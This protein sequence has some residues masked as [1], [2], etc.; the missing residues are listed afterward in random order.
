MKRYHA[1]D[2]MRGIAALSVMLMHASNDSSRPI[3]ESASIAVDFFFILSGFVIAHAYGT[4]TDMRFADFLRRRLIRLYPMFIV[5]LVIGAPVLILAT[6]LGFTNYGAGDIATGILCNLFYLPFLNAG[7]V[8]TK[9]GGTVH[10]AIF[11]ANDP[12]WSLFFEL[13]ANFFFFALFA[14]SRR[15]LGLLVTVSFA[16][17]V[18]V[19][20]LMSLLGGKYG[21]VV[22]AGWSTQNFLAGFPRVFY[23]FGFGILLYKLLDSGWVADVTRRLPL[24]NSSVYLLFAATAL[25]FLVPSIPHANSLYYLFAIAL[26]APLLVLVGATV[27]CESKTALSVATFLGWLSYPLYCVHFPIVRAVAMLNDSGYRLGVPP[28]VLSA[29]VS[30]AVAVAVTKIYDEPVRAWL[31]RLS[32][33]AVSAHA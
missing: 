14:M 29:L 19:G 7:D 24:G 20:I 26:I 11:P 2:G 6:R 28:I 10:G 13:A 4:R 32:R 21:V 18:A 9:L 3:F 17:I 12:S 30:I 5:G 22:A 16:A 27:P 31:T 15:R 8:V 1:L 25:V 23:G 33:R